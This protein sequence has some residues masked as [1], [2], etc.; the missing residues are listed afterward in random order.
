MHKRQRIDNLEATLDEFEKLW[1][2]WKDARGFV[3]QFYTIL[4][5][6]HVRNN[7]HLGAEKRLISRQM[8]W[9]GVAHTLRWPVN[10]PELF[11]AW[12]NCYLGVAFECPPP[13]LHAVFCTS[14]KLIFP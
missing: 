12:L 2:P 6:D 1:L 9:I 14:R 3:K 11:K 7:I 13:A 5:N 8:R 10:R 4:L